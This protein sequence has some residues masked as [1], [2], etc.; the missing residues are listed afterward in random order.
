[1]MVLCLKAGSLVF[2]ATW[3]WDE[4][5]GLPL[6]SSQ[7]I[8]GEQLVQGWYAVAW[9]R[10]E[11]RP[12]GQNIPLHHW[13]PITRWPSVVRITWQYVAHY[14]YQINVSVEFTVWFVWLYCSCSFECYVTVS[15]HNSFVCVC[16]L[17]QSRFWLDLLRRWSKEHLEV[18]IIVVAILCSRKYFDAL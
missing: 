17:H 10:F 3:G 14:L 8:M 15:V 9:G 12:K 6:P 1:M 11:P 2:Y 16:V 13:R 18:S 5:G 7:T 4:W